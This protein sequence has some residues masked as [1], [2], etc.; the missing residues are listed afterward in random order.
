MKLIFTQSD[1]LRIDKYLSA[2]KIDSLPSRS[3]IIRLITE[4]W[5]LVNGKKIKK[6]HLLQKGDELIIT[7]PEPQMNDI[8]PQKIDL[9]IILE[10]K[11]L[12]IINKPAGLTVHPGAGNADNTL[13]NGLVHYLKDSISSG[14]DSTRPGIVH[15]L[16]KNTSGLLIVAKDDRTHAALTALFQRQEI[17]KTYLAITLNKPP[18]KEGTIETLLDRSRSDRKKMAVSSTGRKAVTHY[19]ILQNFEYFS[20]CEINLETG[21]THQIRVHFSHVNCPIL[22]DTVYS[23]RK[24]TLSTIPM[25]FHK[26]VKY[27]LTNHL[28][29]QALHAQKLEFIHPATQK[30]IAVSAPI[31]QDMQY[32]LKWLKRNFEM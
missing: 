12:L 24:R 31:P 14:T 16:D 28:P 32:T 13:V 11:Y 19:K 20:V 15:R 10:D 30:L 5:V 18:Q 25:H 21:R 2:L 8:E 6:S 23:S 4:G 26:K 29:R 17:K 3:S 22:G 1:S 9:D 27:L 7:L